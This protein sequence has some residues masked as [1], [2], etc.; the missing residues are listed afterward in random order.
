[1]RAAPPIESVTLLLA[2]NCTLRCAYCYQKPG[3]SL[4]MPWPSLR[5]SLDVLLAS[6]SP[7]VTV[8][9]SGGEA[10]LAFP[11]IERAARYVERRR[12]A[13]DVRYELT[14][15]GTLL[16][17][18]RLA[19]LDAHRFVV[20]LSYHPVPGSR[21]RRDRA[22]FRRLDRVLDLLRGHPALWH[23]RLR[24]AVTVSPRE[25]RYLAGTV[26][27]LLEKKVRD[28]GLSAAFGQSGWRTGDLT[29][30]ER[31]FESISR[32]AVDHRERTGHVPLSLFRGES[33]RSG[34]GSTVQRRAPAA[35]LRCSGARG[36]A[37]AVDPTGEAWGCVMLAGARPGGPSPVLRLP[38]TSPLWRFGLGNVHDE[39]FPRRLR[40]Y[41]SD[42]A[43]AGLFESRRAQ[44]SSD[45]R[46]GSCR[47]L[48]ACPVCPVSSAFE[49]V[50]AGG[51]HVSDFVCAFTRVSQ[52]HAARFPAAPTLLDR[53]AGRAPVP[54]LV[55]DLRRHAAHA[56][57][58]TVVQVKE[59]DAGAKPRRAPPEE[60][61]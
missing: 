50:G 7:S 40:T 38:P 13:R 21:D 12:G 29:R 9:F 36:T 49:P 56:R 26:R 28:I 5:R 39:A 18:E 52:R 41:A 1:M 51:K 16:D 32:M 30:V 17:P 8:E 59:R 31:Q 19:F 6:P 35:D 42:G 46:C 57:A 37:I 4:L 54:T 60:A 27:Y 48:V 2:S 20:N 53:L 11:M 3:G 25:L 45:A 43:R 34:G 44:R 15:N 10:L 61:P 33:D 24:V 55:R 22:A 23:D 58:R 47:F 14:T